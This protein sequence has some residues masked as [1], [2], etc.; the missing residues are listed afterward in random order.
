[1]IMLNIYNL[2]DYMKRTDFIAMVSDKVD[3]SKANVTKV[4]D[5]F[6]ES[7]VESMIDGSEEKIS[8]PGF[9]HFKRVKRSAR[10]QR[11]PLTGDMM[12]LKE[13]A[14]IKFNLCDALKKRMS[15]PN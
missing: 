5:A 4:L 2:V 6:V 8:F 10:Q 7:I 3:L 11:N 12:Q 14:S 1:M 13:G 15:T 9:G